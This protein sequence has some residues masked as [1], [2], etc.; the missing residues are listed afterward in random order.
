LGLLNHFEIACAAADGNVGKNK[1][2][3]RTQ[4]T[5]SIAVALDQ[6][7]P[8]EA[9]AIET[10]V[11]KQTM[12]PITE[13]TSTA[14][15]NATINAKLFIPSNAVSNATI[16][17]ADPLTDE[18]VA[19]ELTFTLSET[20]TKAPIGVPVARVGD[21]GAPADVFPLQLCQGKSPF[22]LLLLSL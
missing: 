12:T 9:P 21:N 8:T 17:P 3:R 13:G 22:A 7:P 2:V 19:G 11:P 18:V 20:P 16:D 6:E 5:G 14:D 1:Q 4:A 10:M 15:I